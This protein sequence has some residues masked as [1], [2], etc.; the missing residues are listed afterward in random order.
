[1][2]REDDARGTRHL[3]LAL[4]EDNTAT[5]EIAHDVDVVNDLLPNVDRRSPEIQRLLNGLDRPL[6]AC[7]V[8]AGGGHNDTPDG[9]ARPVDRRANLQLA[10]FDRGS[11][12]RAYHLL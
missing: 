11:S 6:H 8:A 2:R 12:H 4:D 3:I 9:Q 5:L 7:A 10:P 1:V